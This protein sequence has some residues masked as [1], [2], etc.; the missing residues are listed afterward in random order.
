MTDHAQLSRD[1]ALA[2]G[3]APESVEEHRQLRPLVRLGVQYELGEQYIL[4]Y[5]EW[6]HAVV[7]YWR[8]FDYRDPTVCLPLIE[9]LMREN[10]ALPMHAPSTGRFGF[11]CRQIAIPVWANTLAEAVARAVIA[12]GRK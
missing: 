1:L 10:G 7:A 6:S 9:W 5:G 11:A 8:R 3:Y 12:V 2:L 4:V